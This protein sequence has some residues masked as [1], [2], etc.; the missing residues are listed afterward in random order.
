MGKEMCN[1]FCGCKKLSKRLK[2]FYK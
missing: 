2:N 1:N